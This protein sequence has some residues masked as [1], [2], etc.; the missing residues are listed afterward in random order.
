L[1]LFNRI[2]IEP[3]TRIYEMAIE[4]GIITPETN[5]LKPAYYSQRST[6]LIELIYGMLTW[7]LALLIK[8]QRVV[9]HGLVR[10]LNLFR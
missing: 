4:K 5:L 9:K 7:P 1:F 6:R 2:R 3:H 10:K 8:C